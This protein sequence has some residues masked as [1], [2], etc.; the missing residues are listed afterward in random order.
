MGRLVALGD[1]L[2]EVLRALVSHLP[3][4]RKRLGLSEARKLGLTLRA[5]PGGPTRSSTSI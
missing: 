5:G 3:A 1:S 4:D 2:R